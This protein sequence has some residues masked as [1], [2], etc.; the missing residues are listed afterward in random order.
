MPPVR[1]STPSSSELA[2]ATLSEADSPT[3]PVYHY[4]VNLQTSTSPGTA[5]QQQWFLTKGMFR[6]TPGVC[7]GCN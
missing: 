1:E 3:V 6:G 4:H 2:V 5:G 7:T